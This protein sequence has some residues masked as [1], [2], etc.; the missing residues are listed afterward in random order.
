MNKPASFRLPCAVLA[1]VAAFVGASA[2]ADTIPAYTSSS[3]ST[4]SNLQDL[5]SNGGTLSV[6]GLTFSDFSF[7]ESGLTSFDPSKIN[8]TASLSNG[9]YYLTWDGNMSLVSNSNNGPSSADLVLKYSVTSA[10]GAIDTIDAAFTGSVQPNNGSTYIA[11]DESARDR[12]GNIVGTTHL[13]ANHN[14][15][16]FPIT[17]PQG[18]LDVTKDITF[19]CANGGF[20]TVSE[21]AQSFHVIPEPQINAL[22]GIGAVSFAL[23]YRR[24][25]K[26]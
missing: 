24:R 16:R 23:L 8:V 6:G 15:D 7:F 20:I 18:S 10:S 9:V 1:L 21:V 19:G 14:N 26:A 3:N 5:S 22:L 4:S 17:P 12:N 11:I 2:F 13:D 25:A